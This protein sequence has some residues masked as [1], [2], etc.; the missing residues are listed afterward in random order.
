PTPEPALAEF[1]GLAW[2]TI[3]KNPHLFRVQTPVNVDRLETMLHA[4]PNQPF[5]KSIL[6]GLKEGFWP[7]ATTRL[8]DEFP[9]TWDNSFRL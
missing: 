4:H 3:Q 1:E 8:R 7:W 6:I 9:I 2:D 5:V